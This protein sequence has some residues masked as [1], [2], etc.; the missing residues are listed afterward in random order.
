MEKQQRKMWETFWGD[1]IDFHKIVSGTSMIQK[2]GFSV[3]FLFPENKENKL[4][5]LIGQEKV[6]A[7][8]VQISYC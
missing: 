3:Y 4:L 5:S 6:S 8:P 1:S 2:N 7:V